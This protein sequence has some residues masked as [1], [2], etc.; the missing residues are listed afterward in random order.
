ML[1]QQN[2][3]KKV[4]FLV[5]AIQKIV[6]WIYCYCCP[7][8][9]STSLLWG[10]QSLKFGEE[11]AKCVEL[12]P[13]LLFPT[14]LTER[15]SCTV[16]AQVQLVSE[17]TQSPSSAAFL[18]LH[19]PVAATRGAGLALCRKSTRKYGVILFI[20]CLLTVSPP[21][22]VPFTL[23]VS[24]NSSVRCYKLIGVLPALP[25][26]LS[27]TPK[28]RHRLLPATEPIKHTKHGTASYIVVM[29]IPAH[30]RESVLLAWLKTKSRLF[31]VLSS[32]L[33]F[34]LRIF[35]YDQMMC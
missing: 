11:A 14:A 32:S 27:P 2:N 22:S 21:P 5:T 16:E 28:P 7:L 23:P 29:G 25:G 13:L 30:F 33:D 3:I 18:L 4:T 17:L 19:W 35:F 9:R 15:V 20:Y 26:A 24:A 8:D 1:K 10:D 6:K 12:P 34:L 31:W